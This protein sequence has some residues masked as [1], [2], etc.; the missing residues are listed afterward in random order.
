MTPDPPGPPRSGPGPRGPQAVGQELHDGLDRGRDGPR[1]L[2]RLRRSGTTAR[3]AAA[4]VFARH[5]TAPSSRTRSTA[6][7]ARPAHARPALVPMLRSGLRKD[8]ADSRSARARRPELGPAPARLRPLE[9]VVHAAEGSASGAPRGG[10]RS[11]RGRRRGGA[12]VRAPPRPSSG[13]PGPRMCP[14]PVGRLD[15]PRDHVLQPAE[16]SAALALGSVRES[17]RRPRPAPR[18]SCTARLPGRGAYGPRHESAVF[19][20]APRRPWRV[21]EHS[22]PRHASCSAS[23]P[24]TTIRTQTRCDSDGDH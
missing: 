11:S 16:D 5:R 3:C 9:Q 17:P 18:T 21:L 15:D 24:R 8:S 1:R 23:W 7:D 10:A 2:L 12:A 22:L 14:V 19:G 6:A 20:R 13:S 4:G